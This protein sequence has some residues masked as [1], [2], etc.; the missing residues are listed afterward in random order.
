M[1]ASLTQSECEDVDIRDFHPRLREHLSKPMDQGNLSWCFGFAASDLMSVKAGEPVSPL[2]LSA[3]YNKGIRGNPLFRM[4]YEIGSSYNAY[5]TGEERELYERG[6]AALALRYASNK[7]I[8]KYE[9][10]PAEYNFKMIIKRIEMLQEALAGN[11]T[12][13]VI[14]HYQQ[15][16][17]LAPDISL[18][19]DDFEKDINEILPQ[20]LDQACSEEV[21]TPKARTRLLLRPPLKILSK[22][23]VK[24]INQSLDRG[25]PVAIGFDMDT[26]Y[27]GKES[28]HVSAVVARRWKNNQCQYK[29]RDSFGEGCDQYDSNKI[30]ECVAAE[31]SY[32]VDFEK[33]YEMAKT[34]VILK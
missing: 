2:H 9:E 28:S 8:C 14:H 22:N 12:E 29:I 32:W 20:V 6:N 30:E 21:Q 31:G 15:L 3:I 24:A 1:A 25:K 26:V 18:G 7:G 5:K 27:K 23:Y 33:F 4:G 19:V 10:F 11:D 13:I 34:A 16:M 17:E